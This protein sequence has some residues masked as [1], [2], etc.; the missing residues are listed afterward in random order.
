MVHINSV[1]T[2]IFGLE[3]L[4][5]AAAYGHGFYSYLNNNPLDT[6]I[7]LILNTDELLRLV[8]WLRNRPYASSMC[9]YSLGTFRLL[10]VFRLIR[11]ITRAHI[12]EK[13]RELRMMIVS[14][15]DCVKSLM[16]AA[17]FILVVT[18]MF[19]VFLTSWVAKMRQ[20][21][22]AKGDEIHDLDLYFS[23]LFTTVLYLFQSILGGI[24]WGLILDPLLHHGAMFPAMLFLIYVAISMLGLLNL[25]TG[26]FMAT[27]MKRVGRDQKIVLEQR[28]E[29]FFDDADDDGSG[30]ISYAEFVRHL[31]D[32]N[33]QKYL[34]E[35]DLTVENARD[36][37]CL[38]DVD[39]RGEIAIADIVSGCL[40]LHGPATALDLS[41][42]VRSYEKDVTELLVKVDMILSE[43]RF[44]N[45]RDHSL[46]IP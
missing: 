25:V 26:V 3:I 2:G 17:V 33:L 42:F 11:I 5:R 44:T 9:L 30:T 41:S 20:D 21:A 10:R 8:F 19:S 34:E 38:L 7:I 14:V 46:K 13:I 1:F 12:L 31:Q 43:V 24:S 36:L 28:M 23:S 4:L 39:A 37:F 22:E 27:V 6:L 40:R 16:W 32:A 18:F 35:I 29:E 45:T 15:V